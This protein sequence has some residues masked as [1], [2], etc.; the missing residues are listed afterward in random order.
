MTQIEPPVPWSFSRSD[1][2]LISVLRNIRNNQEQPEM[3]KQQQK[4]FSLIELL[5]VVAII[6]LIA[7][8]AIPNLMAARMSA[9]EA[10]AS[11]SIRTI[12]TGE[13]SYALS[14]PDIGFTVLAN[15]GGAAPCTPD[16]VAGA[17]FIDNVL[18][19]GQKEGY[20]FSVTPANQVNGSNTTYTSLA[21]PSALNNTGTR[22]FCSDQSGVIY[23][24]PNATGCTPGTG[25][26]LQ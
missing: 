2:K 15:L 5:I 22:S 10:S 17:C 26:V 4:G 9:N 12:N 20:N 18:A 16:P 25:S 7:A 14:Y 13:V 8:I 23:Y 21:D 3:R 6:L 11:G 1:R 24:L 19:Q